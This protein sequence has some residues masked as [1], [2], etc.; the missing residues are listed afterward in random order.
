MIRVIRVRG[1]VGVVLRRH[2]SSIVTNLTHGWVGPS[3]AGTTGADSEWKSVV[4]LRQGM[5]EI[6]QSLSRANQGL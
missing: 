2:L 3:D 6:H 4:R 1:G 5:L